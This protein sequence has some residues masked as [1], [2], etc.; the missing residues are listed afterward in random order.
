[1]SDTP[2]PVP[3]IAKPKLSLAPKVAAAPAPAPAPAAEAAAEPAAPAAHAPAMTP[4]A[5]TSHATPGILQS[6]SNATP[7]AL[8]SRTG[9]AKANFKLQGAVHPANG[10]KVNEPAFTSPIPAAAADAPSPV[11]VALSGLAAAAAITFAVL[12]F[13]KTQ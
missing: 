12:L 8:V 13:F 3:E 9:A 2:S 6:T 7:P 5:P 10:D 1:M 11:I 4:T